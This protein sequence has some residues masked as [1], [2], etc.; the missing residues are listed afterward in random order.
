M[1]FYIP[2]CCWRYLH[3]LCSWNAVLEDAQ[4]LDSI[5]SK[6]GAGFC[7]NMFGSVQSGF[8]FNMFEQWSRRHNLV[9]WLVKPKVLAPTLFSMHQRTQNTTQADHQALAHQLRDVRKRRQQFSACVC[10]P[11]CIYLSVHMRSSRY[12]IRFEHTFIDE[13]QMKWRKRFRDGTWF[14]QLV[15]N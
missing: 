8:G 11:C 2:W 3:Y 1:R 13:D 15:R 10:V 9:S 7:L 6:A 12:N 5:V 14:N 4:T